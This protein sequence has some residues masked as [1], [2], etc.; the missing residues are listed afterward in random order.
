[1]FRINP[2]NETT[3]YMYKTLDSWATADMEPDIYID[4]YGY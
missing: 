2:S 1:M 3:V 4:V